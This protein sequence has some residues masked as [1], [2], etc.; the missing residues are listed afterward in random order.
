MDT[1]E[2]L[3]RE[4]SHYDL[5][6]RE[7][8]DA[9]GTTEPMIHYY[10]KD[11]NGLLFSVVLDYFNQISDQLK[12]LDTID[13]ASKSITRDIIDIV[14]RAYYSK[15]WITSIAMSEFSRNKSPFRALFMDKYGPQ[16]M[17]M[18]R[19]QQVIERLIESGIYGS[20]INPVYAS[21][22]LFSMIMTPFTMASL[23]L[24][25]LENDDWVNHVANLYDRQLRN[26][27]A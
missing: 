13:P 21:L 10:F 25:Q 17:G 19:L 24:N 12:A 14:V 2:I 18:R 8:A 16:G 9:A 26:A 1:T 22:G 23:A 6:E 4:R 27:S 11:K 20:S 15:Y 5:T 7:I 3:L